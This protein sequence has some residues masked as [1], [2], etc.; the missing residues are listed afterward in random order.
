MIQKEQT[1]SDILF[2]KMSILIFLPFLSVFLSVSSSLSPSLSLSTHTH[3]YTHSQRIVT[4][5]V[6][7]A[8]FTHT[9]T[10][11][12]THTKSSCEF[13]IHVII[14]TMLTVF[15]LTVYGVY[16]NMYL[17]RQGYLQLLN[18]VQTTKTLY[19][20]NALFFITLHKCNI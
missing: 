17:G 16:T 12:D 14:I 8:G 13:L 6:D 1:S 10:H 7:A 18:T 2:S 19:N 15:A 4:I 5:M 3:T 11:T 9:R 20:I